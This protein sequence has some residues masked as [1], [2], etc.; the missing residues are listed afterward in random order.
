MVNA[1]AFGMTIAATLLMG[2]ALI[3]AGLRLVAA[4]QRGLWTQWRILLTFLVG[5]LIGYL[6]FL[7]RLWFGMVSTELGT[8]VAAIFLAGAAFVFFTVEIISK[9]AGLD[10]M[11]AAAAD[12]IAPSKR[13]EPKVAWIFLLGSFAAVVIGLY[14]S[15][16]GYQHWKNQFAGTLELWVADFRGRVELSDR[17]LDAIVGLV[18]V[19]DGARA[20]EFSILAKRLKK[21]HPH[22]QALEWIPLVRHSQ[23]PA[24]EASIRAAGNKKFRIKDRMPDGS[25]RP[26]GRRDEYFPVYFVE[27]L[28]GNEQ[29]VGYDLGSEASRRAALEAARD[30]GEIFVSRPMEMVELNAENLGILIFQPVYRTGTIPGTVEQRRKELLGFVLGVFR[31]NQLIAYY[32]GKT[33]PSGLTLKVFDQSFKKPLLIYDSG[34]NGGALKRFIPFHVNGRNWQLEWQ[35]ASD[36]SGGSGLTTA[37]L[38]AILVF[39]FTAVIAFWAELI[40]IKERRTVSL[41]RDRF[42]DTAVDLICIAGFDGYFKR[43]SPSWEDLL[44]YTREELLAEP[45]VSFIHPDDVDR[46]IQEV[47]RIEKGAKAIR[48]ENRYR[49]KNGGWCWLSW[50]AAPYLEEK[51][52]YATARDITDLKR[53]QGELEL[54]R[55]RFD[56]AVKGTEDGIW[57]WDL[58]SDQTYFSDRWKSMLGYAPDEI[59][60]AFESW[61]DLLHPQDRTPTLELVQSY[62]DGNV[63][64]FEMEIRMRHKDGGYRWIHTRGAAVRDSEGKPLRFSGAHTDITERK[65]AAEE[66]HVVNTRL[67]AILDSPGEVIMA[68]IGSDGLFRAWSGGAERLL[69][70]SAEEMIGK[71]TPAIC[72]DLAEL[73]RRAEEISKKLGR[74][75]VPGFEMFYEMCRLPDFKSLDWNLKNKNGKFLSVQLFLNSF[76]VGDEKGVMGVGL[77]VSRRK[78]FE[79]G[80]SQ[81]RDEAIALAQTKTEF[82]ANMSHEIRTPMNG[83]VGM[84]N[85]L[86][87][88][89]LDAEQKDYAKTVRNSARSLLAIINDILDYSKIETGKLVLESAEFKLTECVEDVVQL[90]A[91]EARGK[92]LEL[93]CFVDPQLPQSLHGDRGRLR[94]VLMNLV[95]NAVKFT[96][97]GDIVVRVV[98]LKA[99]DG[100]LRLRF[101]V[102]D[103]GIGISTPELKFLFEAFTQADTST[104]RRFGGTGLGLAIS[105]SIVE[106][107]DGK[108]GVESEAGRGSL[109]WFEVDFVPGEN[110]NA[111]S[112]VDLLK[113][114]PILVLDPHPVTL[115][116]LDVYLRDE[117]LRPTLVGSAEEAKRVFDKQPF[118]LVL[119]DIQSG[120]ENGIEQLGWFK[121]KDDNR[122]KVAVLSSFPSAGREAVLGA[123]ADVFISK[124]IRR[125]H[126]RRSIKALVTGEP[127]SGVLIP[128]EPEITAA[129]SC[130]LK[131]LLVAEDNPVNQ[132]VLLS[133]LEKIGFD[134]DLVSDGKAALAAVESGGYDLVFMDCQMPVLDG[135]E[136]ARRIRLLS[137]GAARV[138]IIGIT[139]HVLKGDREKAL[140]A[141]MNDYL[142]KPIELEQL[143]DVISKWIEKDDSDSVLDEKTVWALRGIDDGGGDVL[144]QLVETF[145]RDAPEKM[146]GIRVG[147]QV[148][149]SKHYQLVHTLKGSSYSLG[150]RLLGD[151]CAALERDINAGG[152]DAKRLGAELDGAFAAGCAALKRVAG[153]S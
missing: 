62:L 24:F 126:L 130:S 25:F 35:A 26:S 17:S 60:N 11:S 151:A 12:I 9:T 59:E 45:F 76:E 70:Y 74:R 48:F 137:S 41:D 105:S 114:I 104:S 112:P 118:P 7:H 149:G 78:E 86:L 16:F 55:E 8:M 42:F 148:G 113:G 125:L 40:A 68:W 22:I 98:R 136:S 95:G 66:L 107:M 36:F 145:L 19:R 56:L 131:R 117:G 153:L 80:L 116:I 30:S 103:T 37:M 147:I 141:G 85:L 33:L 2:V 81:A 6:L 15:H 51:R 5:F 91:S 82:L 106:A 132:K 20:D 67:K 123:G 54:S 77:D 58:S 143:Q 111:D 142:A 47:G 63:P 140:Q 61:R 49:K 21:S 87:E 83:V 129:A 120:K 94:Q 97:A 115:E 108:I 84:T 90:L 109:F 31:I 64:R 122:P 127:L 133:M 152:R 23:R 46:T 134:A 75:I 135:Y 52:I 100:G 92:G 89:D 27:P 10:P 96:D 28:E 88:T 101:E 79:Q 99:E 102:Q 73:G 14:F 44:G 53:T 72:H 43:L 18:A 144:R 69:G 38:I 138:P 121:A 57:D 139:A 1:W 124:P 29:A 3:R 4:S 39:F 110:A 50:S 65:R 93:A 150:A 13:V 32:V 34:G 128:E 71:Q 119:M 146:A